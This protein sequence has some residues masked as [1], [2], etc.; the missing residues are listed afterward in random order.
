MS[1]TSICPPYQ[2]QH[3]EM[4]LSHQCNLRCRGC[5]HYCDIGYG[6]IVPHDIGGKW[7]RDWSARIRPKAFHLMG[8]EPLLNPELASYL[9]T[10][11]EC[12]PRA[13]RALVTNGLLLP[14]RQDIFPAIIATGTR[15]TMSIHPIPGTLRKEFDA[16]LD[17]ID[18]W[19]PRGLMISIRPFPGAWTRLY[20]GDNEEIRPFQNDNSDKCGNQHCVNLHE[21]KLWKCAQLAYLPRI[22]DKLRYKEE[23]LPFLRYQPADI[24]AS[25]EELRDFFTFKPHFC[26]LCPTPG[27]RYEIGETLAGGLEIM[28]Y[29]PL[30]RRKL[31][32]WLNRGRWHLRRIVGG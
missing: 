14:K 17:V 22:I 12:F 23:W 3:L 9:H 4:H 16:A 5:S 28:E 27:Q 24:D 10:A 8:G 11:A 13:K 31:W 19:L 2:F 29:S 21:G 32:H 25:D 6:G 20:K 30:L 15:L 1:T 7:I 26:N 18:Q